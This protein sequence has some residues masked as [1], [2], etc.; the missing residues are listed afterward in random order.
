M[1]WL[2]PLGALLLLVIAL[3]CI[4]FSGRSR[5]AS[6]F[7][8]RF[9]PNSCTRLPEAPRKGQFSTSALGRRPTWHWPLIARPSGQLS[10]AMPDYQSDSPAGEH[11]GRKDRAGH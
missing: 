6:G 1:G 5:K 4:V 9:L 11:H 8:P 3:A 7:L 2:V 10:L